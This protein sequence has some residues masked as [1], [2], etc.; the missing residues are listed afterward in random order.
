MSDE[1]VYRTA[2]AT[3]GLLNN[4]Q[5]Q[6]TFF[7]CLLYIYTFP[8]PSFHFFYELIDLGSKLGLQMA[9]LWSWPTELGS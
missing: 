2:P 7:L 3:P 6:K 8:I 4:V 1:A 5:C 9:Q